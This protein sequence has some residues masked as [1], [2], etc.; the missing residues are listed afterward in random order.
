MFSCNS[1]YVFFSNAFPSERNC[2]CCACFWCCWSP[3]NPWNLISYVNYA[4]NCSVKLLPN[5][6]YSNMANL[7]SSPT[8]LCHV[9]LVNYNDDTFS[10]TLL[11]WLF[12]G[13]VLIFLRVGNIGDV[14]HILSITF[15]L[16][17]SWCAG[18]WVP[19]QWLV[20]FI[21]FNGIK[22]AIW[23]LNINLSQWPIPNSWIILIFGLGILVKHSWC[24]H[25]DGVEWGL[26]PVLTLLM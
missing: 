17:A 25:L 19:L 7:N 2:C 9:P 11:F 6:L 26:I 8:G 15:G 3:P 13:F 24:I 10:Q 21:F 18:S 14:L 12:G 20:K 4:S 5:G 22:T 16:Y 23:S 1:D